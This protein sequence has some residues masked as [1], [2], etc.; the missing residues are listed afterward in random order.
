M[1]TSSLS[2]TVD[3]FKNMMAP[4]PEGNIVTQAV[5]GVQNLV[6]P[7]EEKKPW[8]NPFGGRRRNKSKRTKQRR[9]SR[10]KKQRRQTRRR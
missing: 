7:K 5:D 3:R 8:Y 9:Q 2:A 10:Q 6:S 1:T 4:A